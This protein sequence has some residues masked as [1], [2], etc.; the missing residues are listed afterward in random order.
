MRLS[1]GRYESSYLPKLRQGGKFENGYD[2]RVELVPTRGG[3]LGS[4]RGSRAY[5]EDLR[6]QL[7]QAATRENFQPVATLLAYMHS[8]CAV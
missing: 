5:D 6:N 1:A 2:R 4:R 7:S 3:N 8:M